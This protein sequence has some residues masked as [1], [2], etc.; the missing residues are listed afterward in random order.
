MHFFELRKID[1]YRLPYIDFRNPLFNFLRNILWSLVQI[2]NFMSK[3]KAKHCV[4]TRESTERKT[5]TQ[6]QAFHLKNV[7]LKVIN[8]YHNYLKYYW[9]TLL[10][11]LF[12]SWAKNNAHW[13]AFSCSLFR[14]I[15]VAFHFRIAHKID[16]MRFYQ[17]HTKKK[18]GT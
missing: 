16:L 1:G 13:L 17:W 10:S 8:Y 3:H 9:L 2:Q 15:Y 5:E 11:D 12:A 4:F 6:L 14:N 7:K 18:N